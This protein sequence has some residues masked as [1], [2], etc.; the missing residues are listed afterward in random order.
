MDGSSTLNFESSI[1]PVHSSWAGGGEGGSGTLAGFPLLGFDR[2]PIDPLPLRGFALAWN[3]DLTLIQ[4]LNSDFF[5]L[6]GYAIFRNSDVKRWRPVSKP[7]FVA[8]AVRLQNVR[9]SKPDTVT[10]G[11]MKEALASAGAAFALITIHRE[12]IKRGVCH[13]G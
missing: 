8:R 2:K 6:N 12:R 5:R 7:D 11:S 13:V 1:R 4:V 10:I 3:A 9:P